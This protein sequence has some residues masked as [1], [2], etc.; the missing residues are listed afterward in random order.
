M[1]DIKQVLSDEIRRLARKELKSVVLPLIKQLNDQKRQISVLKKEI[2]VLEK[3]VP[4]TV[5]KSSHEMKVDAEKCKKLRL[6]SKGIV[7]L[8]N[9]YGISQSELASLIG[10]S[11]H[12]VS[13]WEIGKVSPR[14]NAKTAI[15]ALRAIGKK[16]LKRRLAA[17][18]EA[19]AENG[20]IE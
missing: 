19:P 10:V 12:T 16:E 20:D 1:P 5:E 8:R 9:K 13:M 3:R 4:V 18:Q 15:C 11:T 14:L 17:L 2:A 7:K 6:S